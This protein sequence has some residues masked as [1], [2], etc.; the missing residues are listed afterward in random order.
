MKPELLETTEMGGTVHTYP[1]SGGLSVFTRY[2]GCYL[3]QCAFFN[4]RDDAIDYLNS[5]EPK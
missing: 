3:G 2:L 4:K 5:I 1:I